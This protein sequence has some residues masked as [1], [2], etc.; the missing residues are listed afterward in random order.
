MAAMVGMLAEDKRCHIL[1]LPIELQL[2]IYELAVIEHHPL[3]LNFPCNS[4]YRSRYDLMNTDRADWKA[5][6]K[7]PPMQPALTQTCHSIRDATLPIFYGSNV[8][9]ACYCSKEMLAK[10]SD[11]LYMIGQRN[12]E[13]L[14]HFYFY[15][16]NESQDR[17]APRALERLESCKIFAEMNGKMASLSG[18]NCCAHLVTFGGWQRKEGDV[19]F[20]LEPGVKRLRMEGE[21]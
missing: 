15:D 4:S 18:E 2:A 20:A 9:R 16:R 8:F 5:G 13:M 17:R 19:P 3:L 10:P 12:R 6:T 21:V 14:R 7:Y 11:W 1:E